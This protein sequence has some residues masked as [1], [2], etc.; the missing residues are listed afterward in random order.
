[1]ELLLVSVFLRLHIADILTQLV[2]LHWDLQK[3]AS[4]IQ[5]NIL[6]FL[7]CFWWSHV[8]YFYSFLIIK[9]ITLLATKAFSLKTRKTDRWN[10]FQKTC[11]LYVCSRRSNCVTAALPLSN[12]PNVDIIHR[13]K[14]TNLTHTYALDLIKA[15]KDK[16]AKINRSRFLLYIVPHVSICYLFHCL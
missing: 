2:L 5:S 12:T 16:Y 6:A 10:S 15:W 3:Q 8:A 14:L 7:H 4:N 9:Y 1:M 11:V 13:F